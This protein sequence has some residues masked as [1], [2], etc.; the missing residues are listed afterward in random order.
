MQAGNCAFV[1]KNSQKH[2]Q[3]M[4]DGKMDIGFYKKLSTA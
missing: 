1:G 4:W 3:K 2:R